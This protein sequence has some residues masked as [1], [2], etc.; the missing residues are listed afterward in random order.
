M[1]ASP[2]APLKIFAQPYTPAN[3]SAKTLV[4]SG[5]SIPFNTTYVYTVAMTFTTSAGAS[6]LGCSGSP[7]NGLFN[8]VDISGS[9]TANASA[10]EHPPG[11]PLIG[12]TKSNAQRTGPVGG[13]Y[14]VTYDVKVENTGSAR[15][16][17]H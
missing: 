13:V 5:Q 1:V 11:L 15:G 12:V 4:D 7:S 2:G 17:T 3:G 16:L 8:R 10:C 14:T 6:Q 9:T